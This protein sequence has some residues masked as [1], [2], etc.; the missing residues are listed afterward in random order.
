MVDL[1]SSSSGGINN[2]RFATSTARMTSSK[3]WIPGGVAANW[4][5]RSIPI[6][7]I[8]RSQ[9]KAE[10][11][12]QAEVLA[13]YRDGQMYER[14]ITGILRRSDGSGTYHPKT[15]TSLNNII[16]TKL[17]DYDNSSEDR[18]SRHAD[19]DWNIGDNC[20]PTHSPTEREL[21][22]Q[23]EG[24]T[25]FYSSTANERATLN[26]SITSLSCSPTKLLRGDSDLKAEDSEV[27]IFELEL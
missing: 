7:G 11:L 1:S 23:R 8:S 2:N 16:H 13:D 12:A 26:G 4:H 10:D 6:S 14:I 17:L 20:E 18:R 21:T 27:G 22:I 9:S 3:R 5:S 19:E 15:L 25:S 24:S